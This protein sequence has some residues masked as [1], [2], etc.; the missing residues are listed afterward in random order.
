M[1]RYKTFKTSVISRLFGCFASHAFPSFFQKIINRTYTSLMHLDLKEFEPCENYPTLNA[2]F[3]RKLLSPRPFTAQEEIFISPC[4]SFISA[5]GT[6]EQQLALQIKGRAYCVS[7][8]LSDYVLGSS[9]QK[10]EDGYYLNFYLSPKDYHRYHVPIDMRVTKAIHVSGKLYPVNFKWLN[11]VDGLFCENERV[12]LECYSKD[13][14]LFYMVFVGA[15]NVGKMC[16]HFDERIQ[17]NAK[18]SM[19]QLYVYD[20]LLLKKGDEL[21]YFQMGSTIVMLFEKESFMPLVE[22]GT[23]ISFAQTLGKATHEEVATT[24]VE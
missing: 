6:I 8:L 17:T 21:G 14:K 19:E 5:L 12:I 11:K 4:D 1:K 7:D 15:L 18:A 10:L 13:E 22:E 23:K 20:N 2:L 3:T 9:K 16:F 24:P